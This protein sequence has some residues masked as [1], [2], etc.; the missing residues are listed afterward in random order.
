MPPQNHA[1]FLPGSNRE[2]L[3]VKESPYP[4][5]LAHEMVICNRAVAINPIDM[6][7]QALGDMLFKW[8]PYPCVLG[9]DVSG[10][11]VQVGDGVTHFAKGDRVVAI[12]KGCDEHGRN[13]EEGAFQEYLVVR[14]QWT[15]K[16]PQEVSHQEA[17]VLPL[18]LMTSAWGLFHESQLAL[19]LPTAEKRTHKGNGQTLIVWGG[20]TSVGHCAIQL[21][22][23]AGYEVLTTASMK[24]WDRMRDLGATHTFDYRS[25]TAVSDIAKALKGKKVAGAMAIG[26]GSAN[27]CASILSQLDGANK[28]VA[29]ASLETPFPPP[30]SSLGMVPFIIR[31]MVGTMIA[32]ARNLGTGVT[33]KYMEMKDLNEWQKDRTLFGFLEGAM[34]QGT[35]KAAPEPVI[36][37]HGL[38]KIQEGF[39]KI[40][41]GGMSAQKIVVTL[42]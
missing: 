38:D 3:Q 12:A 28:F 17:C 16:I 15:A 7:K 8:M 2:R 18:A 11:V 6:I 41:V 31:F 5:P 10:E 27:K 13:P 36:I 40:R 24:N 34:R 42:N 21:A 35:F 30:N 9:Y 22:V 29:Q 20:S 37:G 39:D 23:A 14:E 19:D 4:K 33:I 32:K 1:S 26:Q 25:S